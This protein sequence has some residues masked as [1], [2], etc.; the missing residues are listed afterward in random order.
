MWATPHW[1]WD[2]LWRFE[3]FSGVVS[4]GAG[5]ARSE[6]LAW[7]FALGLLL[8]AYTITGFDASAHTSEET[9]GAAMNVPKGIVRSVAVSGVAGWGLVTALV[10]ALPGIAEGVSKGGEVVPWIVSVR[11]PGVAGG[12]LLVGI[13]LVQFL[14]GMAA[15]TS[16]S[17]MVF[18]FARDGGLPGSGWLR[19]VD[20]ETGSPV[21]AVWIAAVVAAVLT[22]MVPY[23]MIAAASTVLLYV[24]YVLPIAAGC[25]AWGRGWQRAG[26]WNLRGS[27]RPLAAVSVLGC[28]ALMVIGVQ[29]PNQLALPILGG[30]VVGMAGVWFGWERHR[31]LGPPIRIGG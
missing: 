23:G 20:R 31:F 6:S 7:V 5:F 30:A 15:L 8:P 22:V 13:V 12:L 2:R 19:R 17:R 9:V 10:L 27:F 24:S 18:A 26:P 16:A 11:L 14:C 3:N 4:G 1:E 28:L 25:L 21:V 29:P